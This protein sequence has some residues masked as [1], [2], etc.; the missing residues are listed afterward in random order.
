MLMVPVL[1]QGG[2]SHDAIATGQASRSPTSHHNLGLLHVSC[3]ASQCLPN[4]RSRRQGEAL[5]TAL[6][7]KRH[8]AV[9][10]CC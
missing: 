10:E 6:S 8:E 1:K 9:M 2:G 4:L 3:P 5:M 7:F